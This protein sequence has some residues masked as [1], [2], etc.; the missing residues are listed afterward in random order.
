MKKRIP[1]WLLGGSVWFGALGAFTVLEYSL[2]T[3]QQGHSGRVDWL[4][5]GLLAGAVTILVMQGVQRI[6]AQPTP[7]QRA[8]LS[9]IFAA[10]SGTIGAVVVTR[11]GV[12]KILATVRSMEKYLKLAG[13]GQL[14]H[15]H[16]VFLSEDA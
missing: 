1:L 11:N 7:E 14:P 16:L 8:A 3:H 5:V 4:A 9:A 10:G 13:S 12:P 15:D 6:R 2:S